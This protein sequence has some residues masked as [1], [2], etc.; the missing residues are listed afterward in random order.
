[1]ISPGHYCSLYFY[2]MKHHINYTF[3][4]NFRV[5]KVP[6][7]NSSVIHSS[8]YSA[9][10]FYDNS[11]SSNHLKPPSISSVRR[12]GALHQTFDWTAGLGIKYQISSPLGLHKVQLESLRQHSPTYS[13]MQNCEVRLQKRRRTAGT[14]S[15]IVKILMSNILAF[16][17]REDRIW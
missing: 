12:F 13:S 8:L 10:I 15:K 11:V 5:E 4:S 7:K 6:L 9:E 17:R 16:Q 1:M 2:K 3:L 14:I